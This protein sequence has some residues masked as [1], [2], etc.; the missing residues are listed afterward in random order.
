MTQWPRYE[1]FEQE[2]KGRP[3]QNA[4]SVHAP[5][6]EMAMQN[7]RDV[8]VRRP[9][10]FSIWVVPAGAIYAR[11]AQELAE[12]PSW[13]SAA[14]VMNGSP[15]AEAYYV[16]QKQSQRRAMTYVTHVGEV[17]ART[18]AEALLRAVETFG[19]DKAFVWW[20]C[21]VRVVVRS[22]DD[23]VESMFSPAHHK[24]YRQPKE[25]HVLTQMHEVENPKK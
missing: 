5:D 10:C 12:D 15:P 1:V 6:G 4:G 20:V 8:F 19:E 25:Y 14:L 23:E 21:P 9:D 7:A 11:T 24:T 3:H 13:R 16:F 17:E 18:P 22:Q 2:K